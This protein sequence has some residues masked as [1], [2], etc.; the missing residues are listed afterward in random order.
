M[1]WRGLSGG[2]RRRAWA[3]FLS[4][5]QRFRWLYWFLVVWGTI[6]VVVNGLFLADH[7]L[8][9]EWGTAFGNAVVF[10]V[11]LW[12]LGVGVAIV[13]STPEPPGYWPASLMT[14]RA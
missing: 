11:A 7:L 4:L 10:A 9:G 2:A 3:D 13:R 6:G 14:L 1:I 12:I 5:S 8:R